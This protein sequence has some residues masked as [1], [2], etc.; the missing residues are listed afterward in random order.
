MSGYL[1]YAPGVNLNFVQELPDGLLYYIVV[2]GGESIMPSFKDAM[3]PDQRWH[4]VN[5]IKRRLGDPFER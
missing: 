1:G 3:S 2:N 5:Y 4:L